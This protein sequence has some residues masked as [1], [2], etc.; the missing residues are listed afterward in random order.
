VTRKLEVRTKISS[1]SDSQT[2]ISNSQSGG[3]IGHNNGPT[4]SSGTRN[5]PSESSVV[6][7]SQPT[8]QSTAIKGMAYD[9]RIPVFHGNGY[10]DLEQHLFLCESIWTAK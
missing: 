7:V 10:Q 2:T 9:L 4:Q 8:P 5:K 6:V 1:Q 3:V